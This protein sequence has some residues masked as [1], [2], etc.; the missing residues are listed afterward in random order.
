M[1]TPY[2]IF[3]SLNKI[4][5][6]SIEHFSNVNTK[7]ISKNLAHVFKL[8]FC[9]ILLFI[10]SDIVICHCLFN[11]TLHATSSYLAKLLMLD[12]QLSLLNV[13]IHFQN[14]LSLHSKITIIIYLLLFRLFPMSYRAN[15]RLANFYFRGV[16]TGIH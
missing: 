10:M 6:K 3:E 2:D 5:G 14:T 9:K 8:V 15:F 7:I 4:S 13:S 16:S 12:V 1:V 11:Q